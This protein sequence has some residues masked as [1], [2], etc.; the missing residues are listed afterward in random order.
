MLQWLNDWLGEAYV[1]IPLF[2]N[3]DRVRNLG[4]GRV[5]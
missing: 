2:I 1:F 5:V 4:M 3:F